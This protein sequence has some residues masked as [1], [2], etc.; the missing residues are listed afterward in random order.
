[1]CLHWL[2][3]GKL[4]PVKIFTLFCKQNTMRPILCFTFLMGIVRIS[5]DKKYKVFGC[6]QQDVDQTLPLGKQVYK[7]T[8]V[9]MIE[10][11]RKK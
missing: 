6:F 5:S 2:G 1:M 8:P 4:V 11:G 10:S 3:N 9:I 7:T